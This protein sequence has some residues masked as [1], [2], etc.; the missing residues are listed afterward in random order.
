[1]K[2]LPIPKELILPPRTLVGRGAA[3]GLL[4][5]CTAFG[6]R[7][8]LV[9]GRSLARSGVINGLMKSCPPGVRVMPLQH[10]GGEPTLDQL[11]EL[12]MAARGHGAEWVAG[13]GGGSVLDLA[14]ACAGLLEAGLPV[15]DY[16]DGEAVPPSRIPFIAVPTT[17]GTGSEA[18]IVCVLTNAATNVK[19]S[20]R[21]QSLM[22]RLVIL[23]HGLMAGSSPDVIAGSGLDAY[24]QAIESYISNGA[25]WLTAELSLKGLELVMS[26]LEA[27][28]AD[29]CDDRAGDLLMG[30]YLAGVALSNARLGVVHG[31]AHPLG[32]RYH[33]AHGL[34]CAVCLPLAIEFNRGAVGEK[35]DVLSKMVGGDLL[36]VTQR[37]MT[38]FGIKSPFAGREVTDRTK[39]VAEVMASGSTKANPRLV[40]CDDVERMLDRIFAA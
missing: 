13:V 14:K 15:V 5:E 26:G 7:G 10:Q 24:T 22:A 36:A 32:A 18:T 1:M 3:T 27:V 35:Y 34:A 2:P 6:K 16:H 4:K 29:S 23:D 28:Y 39:L 31:L 37:L 40:M 38:K 25:T 20:F 9:H 30:S 11:E 21:H 19:K 8:V 17:A 33:V 12:L